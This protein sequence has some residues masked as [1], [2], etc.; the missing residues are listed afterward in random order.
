MYAVTRNPSASTRT[1]TMNAF[2]R[3][4]SA[5]IWRRLYPPPRNF[6]RTGQATRLAAWRLAGLNT[7][8]R[9]EPRVV[10]VIAVENLPSNEVLLDFLTL[11][12]KLRFHGKT[13]KPAEALG[14]L[15]AGASQNPVHL[16][17]HCGVV[18]HRLLD[19]RT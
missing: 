3:F 9:I 2:S 13:Q 10:V 14:V 16:L 5:A 4:N 18:G 7:D 1:A 6:C 17:A 11:S 12:A 8:N 19:C 15:K